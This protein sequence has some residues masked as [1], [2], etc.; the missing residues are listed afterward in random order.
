MLCEDLE[1]WGVGG[2]RLKREGI[3]VYLCSDLAA[4]A[5]WLINVDVQQK[6]TQHPPIKK[7][8]PQRLDSAKV[9]LRGR[10]LV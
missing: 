10:K 7:K 9:G 1:G 3:Y 2:G 5:A 8:F 6:P 4:A